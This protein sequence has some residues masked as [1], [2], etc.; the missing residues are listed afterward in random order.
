MKAFRNI[1]TLAVLALTAACAWCARTVEDAAVLV[2]G[3]YQAAKR[4]ASLILMAGLELA[5]GVQVLPLT[6]QPLVRGVGPGHAP[7]CATILAQPGTPPPS[8]FRRAE[9]AA[10]SGATKERGRTMRAL[11]GGVAAGAVGRAGHRKSSAAHTRPHTHTTAS[12][13]AS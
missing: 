8:I 7:H 3:G 2:R 13:V 10:S 9:V 5:A 12:P 4:R 1:L 11:R 6:E